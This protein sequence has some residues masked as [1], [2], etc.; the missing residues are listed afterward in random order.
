[1]KAVFL[2]RDGT[3]A[4]DVN[5]CRRVEDFEILP[6]VPEAIRSLNTCNFKVIVIT[7][8][9]GLA[10]GFFTEDIL[11]RIHR[12]MIQELAKSGARIDA[13]YY[14]PHHPDVNCDCRKPKPKLI[15]QASIEHNI[16]TGLSY[17]VGDK[18]KDVATG[19][20]AGCKGIWLDNGDGENSGT[21]T[22]DYTA[23]NLL[24]A[25]RWIIRESEN[26]QV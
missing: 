4:R 6:G 2:D 3:I 17:M 7:N 10:R 25:A 12:H 16:E 14:C 26:R 23:P 9:S 15:L 24:E 20:A 5:Y 21:I 8:Q 19:Q 22:P 11:D 18:P 1:M 13:I